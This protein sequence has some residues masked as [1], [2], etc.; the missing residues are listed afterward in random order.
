MC[1]LLH[2]CI[3]CHGNQVYLSV[4]I[5]CDHYDTLTDLVLQLV[6]EITQTIHIHTGYAGCQKLHTFDILD[7]IHHI[8]KCILGCPAL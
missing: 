4:T 8:P 6:T 1:P 7:L 3:G 2:R 5:G